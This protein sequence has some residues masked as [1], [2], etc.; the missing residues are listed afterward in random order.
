MQ[1]SLLEAVI[2]P[3]V[4]IVIPVVVVVSILVAGRYWPRAAAFSDKMRAQWK[5][6][7]VIA[8]LYFIGIVLGLSPVNVVGQIAASIGFFGQALIGLA[9][10]CSIPQYE[11]LPVS[12]AIVQRRSAWK[13][14]GLAVWLGLGLVI[15]TMVLG[16]LGVMIGRALGEVYDTSQAASAFSANPFQV[17]L[18]LLSGAGIGEEALFRLLL[19]SIIWRLTG[20]RWLAILI[21]ALAFG[22]Y[23]L[24][25]IDSLYQVFW[26]YPI[27]QFLSSV[28]IGLLWGFVYTWRGYETV[29]LGHTLSDWIPMMVFMR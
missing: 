29:V 10:A 19:L 21:S 22:A 7:L 5:A 11:P 2:G 24:S 12:R 4:I 26:H 17:F 25:P 9:F 23:H 18:L 27:T 13:E 28:F 20:Q 16:G 15:I 3:L 8:V 6:A 1:K 14:I